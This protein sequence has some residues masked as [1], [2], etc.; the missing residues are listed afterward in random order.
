ME[1]LGVQGHERSNALIK[2][3][4]THRSRSFT[5]RDSLLQSPTSSVGL[6]GQEMYRIVLADSPSTRK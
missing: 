4:V 2:L 1:T 3:R 6:A 5:E